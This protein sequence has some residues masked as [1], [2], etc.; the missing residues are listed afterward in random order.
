MNRIKQLKKLQRSLKYRFKDISLLNTAMTAPSWRGRHSELD[1]HDNQRLE[2][3][4]DAVFGV[5]AA[6]YVFKNNPE[7]AEGDL[8]VRVSH[9]ANGRSLAGLAKSLSLHEYVLSFC[10]GSD[11][12]CC[13]ERELEDALEALFGAV[14]CDGGFKAAAALFHRLIDYIPAMPEE[15][16]FGNPKGA[17]QELSQKHA[18]PDSPLYTLV[19]T[20]GPAHD[21]EYTMRVSVHGGY[22][23][24]FSA[25][26]K[27]AAETGAAEALMEILIAE[28]IAQ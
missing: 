27:R 7:L 14:W 15:R 16:W 18:W 5:L 23:A 3:L 28:G 19:K 6:E 13:S 1:C 8:T 9:L 4:G 25:G 20:S 21:P 17:L 24:E 26:S 10:E 2:F 11:N 12:G 22:H